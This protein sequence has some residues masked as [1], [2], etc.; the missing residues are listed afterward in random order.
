[1]KRDIR[2]FDVV[3][4]NFGSDF[5]GSEQGGTRPAIVIQNDK[6]NLYSST[7][8]VMPVT[9]KTKHNLPTHTSIKKGRGTGLE[10]DSVVLAECLRQVS[11]ERIVKV[12]G[13]V[14]SAIEKNGIKTAYYANFGE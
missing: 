3:L 4:V 9:T 5:V 1:M 14:T 11:E 13:S 7:T 2:K 10:K 12:L 8:L 6:G